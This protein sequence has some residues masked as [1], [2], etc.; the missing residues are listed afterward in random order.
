MFE[1]RVLLFLLIFVRTFIKSFIHYFAEN[2]RIF[3]IASRPVNRVLPRVPARGLNTGP[4][5][6]FYSYILLVN[7]K[8]CSLFVKS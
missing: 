1:G 5:L 7:E 8:N 4:V 6:Q 2:L 3:L